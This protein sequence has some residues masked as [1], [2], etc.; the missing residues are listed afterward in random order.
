MSIHNVSLKR[1][2]GFW[3]GCFASNY[4]SGLLLYA[5]YQITQ[6]AILFVFLFVTP[7][8]LYLLFA[9]L[10]FRKARENDWETRFLV[11]GVWIGLTM[12]GTALLMQPV[13]GY[14]WT[15]AFSASAFRGQLLNVSAVLVAGWAAR[16]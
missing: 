7:P 1:L 13:Y 16:K 4:V 5:L 10:Y 6:N 14:P 12:I 15:L 11:V 2:L 8:L 9:W 3:L